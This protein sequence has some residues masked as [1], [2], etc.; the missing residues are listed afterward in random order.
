MDEIK[1]T[2][3]EQI[4]EI[5]KERIVSLE[6][7]SGTRLNIMDLSDQFKVSQTPIKDVLK[8][9]SENGIVT[10][11]PRRGYYVVELTPQD[12]KEIYQ[13][14]RLFEGCAIKD[15][16]INLSKIKKLKREMKSLQKET[17]EKRKKN[18]FCELDKHLH[19]LIIQSSNNKRLQNFF[20]Q[21]YNLVVM[22]F[23]VAKEIDKYTQEHIEIL[24]A[25]QEQDFEKAYKLL[26]VHLCNAE[27]EIIREL[28]SHRGKSKH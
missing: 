9:L 1:R 18:M 22:C 11:R 21:I 15:G 25:L 6:I 12:I 28:K 23:H 19:S 14:R 10:T 5:L 13:L 7:K 2:I 27:N 3:T 26:E 4:Y 24:D 16:K 17:D 8:K 20:F